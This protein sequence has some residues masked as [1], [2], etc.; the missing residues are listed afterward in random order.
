M[1]TFTSEPP[2]YDIMKIPGTA[3]MRPPMFNFASQ[4][5][6]YL[7]SLIGQSAPQYQGS[8][9]PG[10]SPSMQALGVLS[11]MYANSPMPA[12]FGQANA[13]MG[14]FNN[15]SFT[16]ATARMQSGAPDYFGSQYGP[17]QFLPGGSQMG[18]LPYAGGMRPYAGFTPGGGQM[19]GPARM[20]Q[21]A[22]PQSPGSANIPELLKMLM[23]NRA[24]GNAMQ[25]TIPNEGGQIGP[26]GRPMPPGGIVDQ[27]PWKYGAMQRQVAY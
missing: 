15:P 11:Q 27:D 10:M 22:T 20:P 9:D 6:D 23:G 1:G 19:G 4:F 3:S 21:P 26:M 18:A 16:N 17:N 24:G 12:I 7:K 5:G 25:P 8:I 2:Q 13:S 14:R